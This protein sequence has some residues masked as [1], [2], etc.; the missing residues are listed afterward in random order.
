VEMLKKEVNCYTSSK[1]FK[2]AFRWV[3]MV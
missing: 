3:Y 2:H 1:L